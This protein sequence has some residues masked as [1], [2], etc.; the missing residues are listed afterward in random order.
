MLPASVSDRMSDPVDLRMNSLGDASAQA[1]HGTLNMPTTSRPGTVVIYVLGKV[2][3]VRTHHASNWGVLPVSHRFL[4]LSSN[5]VC[6]NDIRVAVR[7]SFSHGH[8]NPRDWDLCLLE[9]ILYPV[10]RSGHR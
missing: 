7:I 9:P 3:S 5:Q 10:T 6:P 2:H 1:R 4:L 8:E